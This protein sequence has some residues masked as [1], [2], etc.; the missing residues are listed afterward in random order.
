MRDRGRA[1]HDQVE[2][3][4]HWQ[5]AGDPEA[6]DTRHEIAGRGHPTAYGTGG[7]IAVVRHLD[8][9]AAHDAAQAAERRLVEAGARR[10]HRHR[11]T[12]GVVAVAAVHGRCGV[13]R[14]KVASHCRPGV[15][16]SRQ[17]QRSSRRRVR[18]GQCKRRGCQRYRRKRDDQERISLVRRATFMVAQLPDPAIAAAPANGSARPC[19]LSESVWESTLARTESCPHQPPDRRS[20]PG[21]PVLHAVA[22]PRLR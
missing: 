14:P 6:V 19:A 22:S 21:R 18:A 4:V 8:D 1:R 20:R 2:I 15:G 13:S 5:P 12:G 11:A 3:G 10:G 9:S 17:C 16:M 7:R